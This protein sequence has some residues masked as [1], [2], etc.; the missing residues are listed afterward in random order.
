MRETEG[1]ASRN[2]PL[3]DVEGQMVDRPVILS[4]SSRLGNNETGTK[5]TR[6]RHCSDDEFKPAQREA[7]EPPEVQAVPEETF[8]NE[9]KVQE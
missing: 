8:V 6:E 2:P 1:S 3:R 9:E 5:A 4:I 7:M